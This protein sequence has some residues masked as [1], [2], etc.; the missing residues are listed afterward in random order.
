MKINI[1]G[2]KVKVTDAIK[3]YTEEKI[4]RLARYFDAEDITANVVLRVDGIYQIAEVTIPAKN[5][6]LRA[7]VKEKDLYQS[8]D[9]A[10]DKLERQI[11]KNKTKMRKKSNKNMVVDINLEFETDIDDDNHKIVRRKMIPVKPMTEEEAILQM[12]LIDHDFFI[13]RNA[14][15]SDINVL[16]RRKDE[17]YG[18]IEI[19]DETIL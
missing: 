15:T 16:Y 17:N 8:I 1:R 3:T 7:E 11:R 14:N 4:G 6:I 12:E 13:F 18:V 5:M 9:K 10:T 2:S 19:S